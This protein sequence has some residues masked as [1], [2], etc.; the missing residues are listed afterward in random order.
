MNNENGKRRTSFQNQN[1][2]REQE[3]FSNPLRRSRRNNVEKDLEDD[4]QCESNNSC[5]NVEI[6]SKN[7]NILTLVN[8]PTTDI[9]DSAVEQNKKNSLADKAIQ[10]AV[11]SF[12]L[13]NY[14][15]NNFRN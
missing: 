8:V 9:N 13:F 6:S 5:E 2:Y 14:I 15:K 11:D 4:D 10:K 3:F 12:I 7:K 1:Y